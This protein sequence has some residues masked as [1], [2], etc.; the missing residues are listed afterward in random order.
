LIL[1]YN[2]RYF[3]NR[4]GVI[5][6]GITNDIN[7]NFPHKYQVSIQLRRFIETYKDI[8]KD[9]KLEDQKQSIAGRIMLKRESSN[10]LIFYDIHNDNVKVQLMCDLRQFSSSEE[11]YQINNKLRRGDWIGNIEF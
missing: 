1:V 5:Y 9:K 3:E 10:K 7:P 8:E 11:F 4:T 6:H 2:S